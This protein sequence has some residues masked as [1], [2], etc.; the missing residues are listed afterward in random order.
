MH[1]LLYVIT[2]LLVMSALSYQAT[3][4]FMQGSFFR[5]AWDLQMRVNAPCAFN[6][7]VREEYKRRKREGKPTPS[8]PASESG[9][10]TQATGQAKINLRYLTDAQFRQQHPQETELM[11]Q[12]VE[13][14]L[15]LLYA[16]A[17]FYQK[18]RYENPQFIQELFAALTEANEKKP[19]KQVENLAKLPLPHPLE[20]LWYEMLRASP[21][22]NALLAKLTLEPLDQLK[23]ACNLFSFGNYLSSGSKLKLRVNLAPRALLYVLFQEEEAV[24]EVVN[25]R[26]DLYKEVS[27]DVKSPEEATEEFQ[28][29]CLRYANVMKFLPIL[30]FTVNKTNPTP[31]DEP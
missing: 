23:D 13:D 22:P 5:L 2:L 17:P 24:K 8:T 10:R 27:Q 19:V 20:D 7:K 6:E 14:L 4:R 30:D 1:L 29:F 11:L 28:N 25:S 26:Y 9:K 3:A 16:D 21:L 15:D 12:L 18:S 31:Y